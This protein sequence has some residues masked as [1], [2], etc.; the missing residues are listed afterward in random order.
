[1]RTWLRDLG[2]LA[3]ASFLLLAA[4]DSPKEREA[5]YIEH[6]K[7]LYEQGDIVKAALEFRNALQIN[8]AGTDAQYYIGLIAEKR[9][10]LSAA[11]QAFQKVADAD[12]K[13][14]DAHLKAGRYSVLAGDADAAKRYGDELIALAAD[15]PDGHTI[16]AAAL[17]M[18]GKFDEAEKEANSAL[19]ID[20]KSTDALIILASQKV[21]TNDADAALALIERGLADTPKS[22]DLLLVKLRLMYDKKRI[23]DVISVLR[24]LHEI[25][26]GNS[27]FT[28]DLGNQLAA[29][30]DTAGAETV[31]KQALEANQDSDALLGAY[32]TFLSS[33]KSP[34]AAMREIKALVDRPKRSTNSILLLEKLYLQ[35]GKV[36]DAAVLMS[37]LQK[38]GTIANDR[39]DAQVELARIAY[40]KGQK[41]DALNQ[42]AAVLKE[43][44]ANDSALLLRG[45]IMLEDS[46]FDDAITDA[47]SLLRQDI[48]ST[49]GLTI[50]A[51][52]YEA[53]SE[54]DLAIDT[55]RSLVRLAPTNLDARLQLAS[56]LA[57]KSPDDA[58]QNLDAAIA[59]RPDAAELRVQKAEY[60][61]RI[62]SPDKA[63]V[64][65]QD[66]LKNA[67]FAGTAH[68]LL[69]QAALARTDYK[70]AI[71]E[72]EQAQ[73][74]G[75]P[76]AK[77]GSLVVTAYVRSGNAADAEKLLNDRIASNSKDVDAILLL[78][79]MRA[80]T[81][82]FADSEKLLNQAI[83]LR[84]DDAGQY[85][86]LMQVLTGQRK[87]KEASS[88]AAD[89]AAKFPNNRDV[90]RASAIAYDAAG[91]LTS[92]K[93][94]Y[95]KILAKW[96]GDLVAA[97]NLAALIADFTPT[98]TTQLSRARELSEKFRN[99]GDPSL[100]D[101][102]G[103]VLFRQG[104]FDDAT[105]LLE[106]VVSLVPDNQQ[107]QFHYAMAL[108]EK[109]LTIKAKESF[110]K[111]LGGN[112]DYRGV[113][114]ARKELAAI[115]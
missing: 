101:T 60:L 12:P 10:D 62:G 17:M 58:I 23:P 75:E 28:I 80:Q 106:K 67:A 83:A 86:D 52:A 37:D 33:S 51:K 20:S 29:S 57:T 107:I 115:Q 31:F 48:N 93:A 87:F 44:S 56:L 100:L 19:A 92:A 98:D 8:P 102:L 21:R 103:W 25:D 43:D 9:N 18:Q 112:P 71:T 104:N 38:N 88:L 11:A 114:E 1:M 27:N 81:G 7:Q 65:A 77:V 47:R 30:G 45:A 35:A 74:S 41:P 70:T 85:L 36:D 84:P 105:I 76:F 78:A 95:E 91:D 49:G 42:L 55:L 53:T 40:L 73:T 6:G 39:L 22:T 2:T 99:S 14:F 108:K 61:I 13:H 16:K 63:E 79:A 32:A 46:K 113:E 111:A 109:G 64:V 90:I 54:R 50:L 96:P 26:P 4:C 110:A 69:G 5:K 82:N 89:A 34:E 66:L 72:F 24:Q 97:N 15:K 59:L 3:V 68:R 94:G